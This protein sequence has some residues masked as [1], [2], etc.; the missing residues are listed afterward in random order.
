MKAL[1]VALF[2]SLSISLSAQDILV[3]NSGESI[4]V[5]NVDCSPAEYVYYQL[6]GGETSS[7]Q[8][9]KKNDVLIIRMADGTKVDPNVPSPSESKE[10]KAEQQV[11]SGFPNVDLSQFHGFLLAKGNCVYVTA[12]RDLDYENAAVERIKY[13]I[14]RLDYWTVVDK[15]EQAHFVIQY[16]V[17]LK[18][19]DIAFV[20]LKTRD[21]YKKYPNCSFNYGAWWDLPEK[22]KKDKKTECMVYL[23]MRSSED[24]NDNLEVAD[25]MFN[26]VWKK[27]WTKELA[28]DKAKMDKNLVELFYIP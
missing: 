17:N 5:K 23:T 9:I 11:E 27:H 15:P 1:L 26:S 25:E 20:Y 12:N 13:H 8:K 6:A 18:G 2:A 19:A 22:M 28:K 4:K 14:R 7:I 16:G 10:K 24:I 3:L 21:S